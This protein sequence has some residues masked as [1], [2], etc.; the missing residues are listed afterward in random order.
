MRKKSLLFT[1]MFILGFTTLVG[2]GKKEEPND[3]D[4]RMVEIAQCGLRYEAPQEWIPYENTNLYPETAATTEGDIY[5]YLRF[6]YISDE[7]ME[8]LNEV[9]ADLKVEDLMTPI[10]EI[11]VIHKDKLE[12]PRVLEAFDRYEKHEEVGVVQGDYHY[13]ILKD[14]KGD[15]SKFTEKQNEVYS[16]LKKGVFPLQESI[17]T[18]PFDTKAVEESIEKMRRTVTFTS[19]TLEGKEIDSTI[20]GNYDLTIIN[21]WASYC[22]P[23]INESQVMETLNKK[24]KQS[25]PNV[26]LIQ[27]V[28]DT[29]TPAAEE[30]ALQAKKEANG[31][32]TSIMPDEVLANW[33]LS[34]LGGLPTTIFVNR[35]ALM[36]GEALEGVNTA[37]FYLENLEKQLEALKQEPKESEKTTETTEK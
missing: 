28:I 5:S 15:F 14:Y 34:N 9:S 2:C 36:V 6:N 8:K 27:V 26:N 16:D 20:L 23:D 21:F 13:F 33:I 17:E 25:Y 18:F 3:E 12:S 22:Y 35:E 7:N 19:K 1:L 30:V 10:S 29:P 37:D 32:Y 24:I 4:S 11:L 31:T